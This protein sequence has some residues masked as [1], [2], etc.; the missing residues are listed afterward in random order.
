MKT[1]PSE[2][3]KTEHRGQIKMDKFNCEIGLCAISAKPLSAKHLRHAFEIFRFGRLFSTLYR[4]KKTD[5]VYR[6]SFQN[7]KYDYMQVIS[8]LVPHKHKF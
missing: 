3:L 6:L 7:F 2:D 5:F 1:T 4:T 8:S